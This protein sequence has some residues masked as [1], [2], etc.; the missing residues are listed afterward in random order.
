MNYYSRFGLETLFPIILPSPSRS[1]RLAVAKENAA[2][3]RAVGRWQLEGN[4]EWESD[5][6]RT[7]ARVFDKVQV[8]INSM[9]LIR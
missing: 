6:P 8:Y 1:M 5:S 9:P 7:I 2:G 4:S 3:V